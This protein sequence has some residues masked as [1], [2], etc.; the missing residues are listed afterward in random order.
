MGKRSMYVYV[1]IKRVS[2]LTH[3]HPIKSVLCIFPLLFTLTHF[4]STPF[5]FIIHSI[6]PNSH[7]SIK[8]LLRTIHN[9]YIPSSLYIHSHLNGHQHS[10]IPAPPLHHPARGLTRHHPYLPHHSFP[11]TKQPHHLHF[12]KLTLHYP[13]SLLLSHLCFG[14]YHNNYIRNT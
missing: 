11:P 5:P 6:P 13:I 12:L 7:F 1:E 14:N 4:L 10:P 3:T 9:I 2:S 8:H